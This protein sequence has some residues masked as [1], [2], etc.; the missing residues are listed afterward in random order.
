MNQEHLK[1]FLCIIISL[2][3]DAFGI[4]FLLL[5]IRNKT[6]I[7]AAIIVCTVFVI[8]GTVAFVIGI[9]EYFKCSCYKSSNNMS[10]DDIPD[11]WIPKTNFNI[12]EWYFIYHNI[13]I[14][15]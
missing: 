10:D 6:N 1:L 2:L 8:I 7:T 12:P 14:L 15:W 11:I 9:M 4:I 13:M 5:S 3:S